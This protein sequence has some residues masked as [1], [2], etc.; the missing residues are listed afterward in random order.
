MIDS[1]DLVLRQTIVAAV[2]SLAARIG[3]Q[4]PN[5]DWR[6]RVG[7]GTG[8][9]LNCAL[10]DLREDRHHR[11]NEIRVERD[12]LRR[13]HAPFLMTCHYL[14]SAWNSAKESEAVAAA[15]LEHALL[16]QVVVALLE[17]G[18]LTP[19]EV[20]LPSELASL[21]ADWREDSFDT[22]IL[23]PEGFTKIAEFWGTMGR[24]SPWRPV[25]W[26][27]VTVPVSPSPM[28]IEGIVTSLVTSIGGGVPV[29]D[30]NG[31]ETLVT[32]GGHVLDGT[33]ANAGSPVPIAEAV[34]TL[35]TLAGALMGRAITSDS[36][37]FVLDGIVPGDYL[38]AT[39][40]AGF[41]PSAPKPLTIPSP[42]PP[43]LELTFT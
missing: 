23:P 16:G 7:A 13:W 22:D 43:P 3:F 36:G 41:P 6:Q 31:A 12:P 14:L 24:T 42:V 8:V 32:I 38:L 1:L 10:V 4:P 37:R 40:A 21:P 34:V 26:I 29:P 5:D 9:W 39:R 30:A 25:A 15:S 17:R 11:S 18:Q 35:S 20:L 19:A 33:G 2:P 27:A 28:L